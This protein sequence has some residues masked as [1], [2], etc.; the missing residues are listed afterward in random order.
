MAAMNNFPAMT[1]E[2]RQELLTQGYLKELFHYDPESGVF[3]RLKTMGGQ[4]PGSIAGSINSEGYRL[5]SIKG[6]SYKAARLAHLYMEG[7]MPEEADHKNR[8]RHDDR[9]ENLRQADHGQN[10][11]NKKIQRNNTSGIKCV[12]WDKRQKLWAVQVKFGNKRRL[13]GRFDDIE[14]AELIAA[15]ARNKTYGAFA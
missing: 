5:I 1:E 13:I 4:L 3:T 6:K 12:Y 11:A 10:G 7:S 9:W 8:V 15:E 14:L 2:Q